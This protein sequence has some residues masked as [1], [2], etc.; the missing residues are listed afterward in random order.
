LTYTIVLTNPG[1][2]LNARVTDTLPLNASF[3]AGS[4]NDSSGS[5]GL[6]GSVLTWTGVVSS[7]RRVTVTYVMTTS[8]DI[9]EPTAVINTAWLDDGIGHVLERRVTA[10][11]NAF[12]VYLPLMRK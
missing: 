5:W 2:L 11:I 6:N 9:T 12:S 8:A 10:M 3:V 7:T 4:L 1:P